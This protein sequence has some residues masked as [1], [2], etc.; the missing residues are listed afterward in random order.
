ME[1]N[2]QSIHL[3]IQMTRMCGNFLCLDWGSN[4]VVCVILR[5]W[6]GSSCT[7]CN[8]CT[9]LFSFKPYFST[10]KQD[11]LLNMLLNQQV[12]MPQESR[13]CHWL[14]QKCLCFYLFT[15]LAPLTQG[16]Q[17]QPHT[18]DVFISHC[19]FLSNILLR[20]LLHTQEETQCTGT[21]S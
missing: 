7:H 3:W 4:K 2:F 17:S 10:I 8:G 15:L 11:M 1:T 13:T 9:Q 12:D 20:L 21:K 16:A 14:T 6:I 19:P 5:Y 18:S